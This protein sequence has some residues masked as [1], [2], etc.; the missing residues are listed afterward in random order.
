MLFHWANSLKGLSAKF[1]VVKIYTDPFTSLI[2]S[3][4]NGLINSMRQISEGSKYFAY[5]CPFSK[6][7]SNT[8]FVLQCV[9]MRSSSRWKLPPCKSFYE[10]L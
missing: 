2:N 10:A 5:K 9:A 4:G 8:E 6:S 3:K 7:Q 1:F